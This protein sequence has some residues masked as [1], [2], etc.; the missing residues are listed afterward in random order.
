M[1]QY[2][3]GKEVQILTTPK[4]GEEVKVTTQKESFNTLL[5]PVRE[6]FDSIYAA[7]DAYCSSEDVD[8]NTS[9]GKTA[10]VATPTNVRREKRGWMSYHQY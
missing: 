9:T 7:I 3:Y 10:K 5:L 1:Q 6:D 4:E 8:L 2:F